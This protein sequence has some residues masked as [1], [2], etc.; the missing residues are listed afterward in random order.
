M[1]RKEQVSVES[2]SF[3]FVRTM[4]VVSILF[5]VGDKIKI[6]P[7]SK[8]SVCDL[9]FA[10]HVAA[11]PYELTAIFLIR[12]RRSNINKLIKL[13]VKEAMKEAALFPSQRNYMI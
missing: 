4:H 12:R 8:T 6:P 10:I 1:K 7:F 2:L 13:K 9:S 11:F 3:K 5:T